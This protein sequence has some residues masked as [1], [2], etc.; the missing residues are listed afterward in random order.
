MVVTL[1]HV[2]ML[3]LLLD[4]VKSLVDSFPIGIR[5]LVCVNRHP[6][7]KTC[8]LKNDCKQPQVFPWGCLILDRFYSHSDLRFHLM[9]IRCLLKS[10]ASSQHTGFIPRA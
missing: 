9:P 3:N 5:Q 1:V 10:V 7:D 6:H 2:L 4:V 8:R